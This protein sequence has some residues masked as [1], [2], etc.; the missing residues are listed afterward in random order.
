M[1]ADHPPP[2]FEPLSSIELNSGTDSVIVGVT[3]YP[4]RAEVTR[5]YALSVK[6]GLNQVKIGGLP[7]VFDTHSLRASVEGAATI[8]DVTAST[9]RERRES[10]TS[11]GLTALLRSRQSVSDALFRCDQA[12]DS[13]QTYITSITARDL[14]VAELAGSIEEYE[15]AGNKVDARRAELSEQLEKLDKDI[16]EERA[17]LN[18][19]HF[20]NDTLRASVV[21]SLFAEAAGDVEMTLIYG[22]FCASWKARY[23]IRVDTNT[24]VDTKDAK[25][26]SVDITFKA[27]VQQSTGEAWTAVPLTLAT[28]DT[29]MVENEPNLP[30]WALGIN[31]TLAGAASPTAIS[32]LSRPASPTFISPMPYIPDI[33]RVPPNARCRRGV[34]RSLSRSRSRSSS[35]SRDQWYV[36]PRGGFL[37]VAMPYTKNLPFTLFCVPGLVTIPS[38]TLPGAAPQT[39]TVGQGTPRAEMSWVAAPK[40]DN[41]VN[42]NAEIARASVEDAFLAF[43][44]PADVYINGEFVSSCHVPALGLNESFLCP[45]GVDTSIQI[46]YPPVRTT[47]TALAPTKDKFSLFK[48]KSPECHP[49]THYRYLQHI[50]VRNDKISTPVTRLKIVDQIPVANDAQ[51][52][53]KLL[54]PPLPLPAFKSSNAGRNGDGVLRRLGAALGLISK[55]NPKSD[56]PWQWSEPLV[57]NYKQVML[58]ASEGASVIA[59]WDHSMAGYHSHCSHNLSWLC[60]LPAQGAVD[61]TLEWEVVLTS[62]SGWNG[63]T[64]QIYGL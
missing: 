45:L 49:A 56:T 31:W 13:L 62:M 57:H 38:N 15:S 39:L 35:P 20:E 11:A 64:P 4:S 10:L 43:G 8:H 33:R 60:S 63:M 32:A 24:N 25:S 9:E 19:R 22:V 53:M 47:T 1:S 17:R 2:A 51:I 46:T 37:E 34:N 61:L 28:A 58:D 12:R 30:P 36:P 48:R 50:T 42:L 55:P 44:G 40:V 59:Q 21:L 5:H 29:V 23:D 52:R 6:T 26:P 7:S 16:Q 54:N 27:D 18:K 3:L 14:P 41:R